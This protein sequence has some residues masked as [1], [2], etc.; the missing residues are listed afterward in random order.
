M[1]CSRMIHIVGQGVWK[2][3]FLFLVMG[4]AAGAGCRQKVQAPSPEILMLRVEQVPSQ[5][6]DPAWQ[7][8]PEYVGKL[9]LQDIVEPRQLK[10]TTTE[11]RVR[12]LEDGKLVAFRLQWQD[13]TRDELPGPG[14]FLDACALQ[15]P[16]EAGATLPAPQMGEPG[17]PVEI[18]FWNAAWQA[19]SQ[20]RKDELQA[21]YPN[22]WVDHYPYQ[23]PPLKRDPAM[24]KEME[25]LY[26]PARALGNNRAGPRAMPVEEYVAQGP[27]TVTPGRGFG[28]YGLGRHTPEGWSVVLSRDIPKSRYVALAIWD[29]AQAEAGGRKMR[30]GWIPLREAKAP[31]R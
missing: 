31:S 5:P 13:P 29:G 28:S 16:M 8:A 21:L 26:L 23:A 6:E 3:P 9:L 19:L 22:A 11:V 1:S 17:K 2:V 10:E 24:Q 27:G 30:T 4:L 15:V 20:G 18:L 12:A 14:R 7:R 25:S